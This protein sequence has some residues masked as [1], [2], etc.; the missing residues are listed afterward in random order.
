MHDDS[1]LRLLE[2]DLRELAGPHEDDERLRRAIRDQLAAQWRPQRSRR[3]RRRVLM[4]FAGVAAAT[5][6]AVV[7]LVALGDS[8]G[9]NGLPA[10]DA[11]IIHHALRAVTPPAN[12]ILHV[13][14]VGVQNGVTVEGETWQQTSPPYASRGIKGEV[15][16]QGEFGDNGTTSFEYD[17]A[18]NTITEQ[19]DS[20]R[21]TFADPVSQVRQ[22]L[23]SGHAQLRGEV[24]IDGRA[25]YEIDLANG[26]VGYFEENDYQPRYLDDPQRGGGVL[27]L[28]VTAYQYLPMT[29]ANRALLSV[30]GEHPTAH[31]VT[32][33]GGALSK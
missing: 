3:K 31:L 15:G 29:A 19:P 28:R 7:A 20:S 30:T 8:T 18:T 17:P 6:A 11:A 26:H 12:A 13:K 9:S 14:V 21:P 33:S 24:R 23:A 27:R 2:H 22:E 25:L 1:H 32:G 4:R 10:A 5:T 16:H